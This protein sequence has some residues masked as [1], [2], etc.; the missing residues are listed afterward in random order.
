MCDTLGIGPGYTGSGISIFG[1]NSDREADETQLVLS[2]P[3]KVYPEHQDLQ[4]TYITIPQAGATHAMVISKPFWIWG[5]EMGVN[6]KG[7]AIGNEALFTRVKSENKPGL[8][9]MDLLRLALE[10]GASALE[11]AQVII[12]LLEKYG[13]A[14]PCG[15][16]D[17]KFSYMNSFLIMDRA[18]IMTLET[19]GRD[20]ALKYQTGHAAISNGISITSDWDQSSLPVGTDLRTFTDPLTT[21]FAGSKVRKGRN[22]AAILKAKGPISAFDVFQMLRSHN[23]RTHSKGFNRDVCM[24]ASDPLIRRSQT[25]GSMV[26]EMHQDNKFRI[27]VTAGSAP[28]LTPFKPFMPA[29]PFADAG[30]GDGCYSEDSYWWRHEQYHLSAILR[31]DAVRPLAEGLIMD[32]E[33][34]WAAAMPAHEWDSTEKTLVEVSHKAFVDAENMERGLIDQM[35]RME[36]PGFKLSHL[37]WRHMAGRSGVPVA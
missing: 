19:A 35:E 30:R 27:F 6:E 14:G 5:A 34:E 24:H 1:K 32:C 33:S 16:R 31:Y 26:V 8:I 3:R 17:K 12:S 11:A 13:Q 4:C 2:I 7:V 37:F 25:T 21:F 9:G 20:Y 23:G 29:A 28:C 36:R 22:D 18:C 15:Y 10:R